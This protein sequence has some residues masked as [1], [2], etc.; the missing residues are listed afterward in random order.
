MPAALTQLEEQAEA[1]EQ[2]GLDGRLRA[3]LRV[4][5]GLPDAADELAGIT[6][7]QARHVV[8]REAGF[9]DWGA[10]QRALSVEVGQGDA[11]K[12]LIDAALA[13]DDERVQALLARWPDLASTSLPCALVLGVPDAVNMLTRDTVNVEAGPCAWP[14]LLY[15]CHSRYAHTDTDRRTALAK[16]LERLLD[17]GAD[18]NAGTREMESVRGFRTALGAAIGRARNPGLAKALLDAGADVAD[19]P[20]LYEGCAMWEAI[21]YRDIESL[22]ALLA[23]DPPQWHVCH[24]LPH[25]LQYDDVAL[26]RVLLEHGGDPNWT[27]GCWGFDGN[28]L[29]EAVVLGNSPAVL[30]ALLEHGAQ[31][32]FADR[33][34]RTPLALA[35]CLNRDA[36]APL[37]REHGARDDAVRDIDHWVGACFAGDV[38][39]AEELV[40][41]RGRF[42]PADHLWL[43]RALRM[44]NH[45]A[46]RLLLEGGIDPNAMDD[47]GERPLHLAA[48]MDDGTA[49]E[50]LLTNGADVG[51]V[52][53]AG[54][55]P[56]D[57]ALTRSDRVTELLA[58]AGAPSSPLRDIGFEARF[59]AAADAVFRGDLA[60]FKTL[61]G[62]HPELASARSTRPHRCTLLH[63]LG[64]NGFEVERQQTPPNAVAVIDVLLDAGSDPNALCYTYRGGPAQTTLG[65]LASSSHPKAAGLTL[66]MVSALARGGAELDAVY[67]LLATIHNEGTLP[68]GFDPTAESSG[69]AL[70]EAAALSETDILTRLLDAGVDINARRPDATT[71]LHHA[72]FDGNA[73]LVEE[74]LSRGADLTRRDKVFD[75]TAAGWA[76]A[77]GHTALGERLAERLRAIEVGR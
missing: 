74:L 70:I 50:C 77:G 40:V 67:R 36:L 3:A 41:D 27:M 28:C 39:A 55:T 25:A 1:L 22:E 65:L 51:Q 35:T 26:T 20:T 53:F 45:T 66:A 49:A 19:G 59:E 15:L 18:P 7:A 62:A 56:L 63:Y 17:L 52:N 5:R 54:E 58:N 8:A 24:A 42:L 47:D 76:H 33:D 68:D 6:R 44:A 37:L 30:A 4:R 12:A 31:P 14:P 16:L 57:V 29:H 34:G 38:G 43:C 61:F 2:A 72:A 64:A 10:V 11:E 71:A 21:R 48:R 32:D 69:H 9:P 73:A 23:R 75:G 46:V 60:A 13:G